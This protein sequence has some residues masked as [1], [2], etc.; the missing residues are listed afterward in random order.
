M[1]NFGQRLRVE[2]LGGLTPILWLKEELDRLGYYNEIESDP[3]THKVKRLFYMHPTAIRLW[4]ENPDVLLLDC[5]YKTNRFNMPLLNICGVTGNN[6]TPQFALCF[7]SS[8][9]EVDYDW[10]L[11]QLRKCMV[12]YDIQEPKT[13]ITD[14]E[15]ALI[16]EIDILFPDSDHLLCRWHV[17]MNV[18][19]NCKKHFATAEVWERFYSTWQVVLNSRTEAEYDVHLENLRTYLKVPVEY[20]EK[21]WLKWKEKLVSSRF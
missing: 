14:R 7:L 5:T 2:S 17:N 11:T 15:I 18:V 20:L 9:Q 16:T 8:E 4:K 10:A 1:Y 6:K 21:T 19:K 12:K 13:M 3:I